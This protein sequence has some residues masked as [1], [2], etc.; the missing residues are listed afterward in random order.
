VVLAGAESGHRE[1]QVRPSGISPASIRRRPSANR[2]RSQAKSAACALALS[3]LR[4][5]IER[6]SC[7]V[8]NYGRDGELHS[9]AGSSAEPSIRR[10]SRRGLVLHPFHFELHVVAEVASAKALSRADRWRLS[11]IP[12]SGACARRTICAIQRIYGTGTAS[13][14]PFSTMNTDR[15]FAGALP[16]D[17]SW[18]TLGS[19]RTVSPGL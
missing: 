9:A 11:P 12:C 13:G 8:R 15:N 19:I 7:G 5:G 6:L 2:E 16:A 17:S 4:S 1:N 3:A 14:L 10:G 18:T